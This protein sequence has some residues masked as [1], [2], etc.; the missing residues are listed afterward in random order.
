M[1]KVR[2]DKKCDSKTRRRDG[3]GVLQKDR[4]NRN[5]S[6]RGVG[7]L[8]HVGGAVARRYA[9]IGNYFPPSLLLI[10]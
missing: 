6:L 10:L 8:Q 5:F 9:G 4:E 1:Q 2:W 7:F 3:S